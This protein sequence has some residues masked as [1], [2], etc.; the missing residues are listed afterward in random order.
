[1]S[2]LNKNSPP[3]CISFSGIDGA[4]KSTQIEAL[5]A[6]LKE[7]GLQIL[8]IVFWDDVARLTKIREATGHHIFKGEKGVGTPLSPINRRDKNV[9]SWF[10]TSVRLFLY[11]IDA[12]SVRKAIDRALRSEVDLVIFD[13]FIYDELANL[14]LSNPAIRLY[15]RLIMKFVP[16]PQISFFLDADPIQARAR[17]PE[18]PIEF[19]HVNRHSYRVL[20]ELIGG[21]TVIAPMSIRAAEHAILRHTKKEISFSIPPRTS[22]SLVVR[23]IGS[24]S[25]GGNEPFTAHPNVD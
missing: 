7:D 8:L 18:Y 13:R 5:C 10:M 20:N 19:L 24:K 14:T 12:I 15:V 23:E 11:T 6:R 1:M 16:R 17:K 22:Q 21:M 9:R 4:G 25:A 3:K 2:T